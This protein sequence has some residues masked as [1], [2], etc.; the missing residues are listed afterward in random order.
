MYEQ[1]NYF[2]IWRWW[3]TLKKFIIIIHR[4]RQYLFPW[5]FP[6]MIRLVAQPHL[7]ALE[8][9]PQLDVLLPVLQVMGRRTVP[10][11]WP[12]PARRTIH[13][14][15]TPEEER[16]RNPWLWGRLW[17]P[18][19]GYLTCGM[20]SAGSSWGEKAEVVVCICGSA[21]SV[22]GGGYWGRTG[23]G[24]CTTTGA[25]SGCSTLMGAGCVCTWVTRVGKKKQ[26]CCSMMWG[27]NLTPILWLQ[28][29]KC[30]LQ[31]NYIFSFL[32]MKYII[33]VW[34]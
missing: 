24:I 1:K 7:N 32:N 11:P 2:C 6:Q 21:S 28:R 3:P 29:T 8:V 5:R 9:L 12:P 33:C 30:I 16:H 34:Y 22:F 27:Y 17:S 10:A 20:G 14:F 4:Q 25:S 31:G 13:E 23:S 18:L 19:C 26:L 15:L